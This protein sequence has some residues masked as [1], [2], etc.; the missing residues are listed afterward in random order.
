MNLRFLE[1]FLWIAK[2]GSFS[3]AAAKLHTTQT[4]I[5][6]R[7]RTLEQ[8][9]GVRLFERDSRKVVL[10]GAGQQLLPYAEQLL[11]LAQTM[12]KIMVDRAA[13][14]GIVT[15]GVIESVVHSWLPE[16]LQAV[17][18][19]FPNVVLEVRSDSTPRLRDELLKGAIDIVILTEQ[20]A[21][22]AFEN[23]LLM[24]YPMYWCAH[25]DV[26]VKVQTANDFEKL[27][28][29]QPVMTFMRDTDA[30]RDVRRALANSPNVRIN[31]FSSIAAIISVATSG[32]GVAGLA[33]PV[34]DKY[35]SSHQLQTIPVGPTL[36]DLPLYMAYPVTPNTPVIE[37]IADLIY[38]LSRQNIYASQP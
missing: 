4:A 37:Q 10:T 28:D 27:L 29:T 11:G 35:V 14:Q 26:A 7:I 16:L 9:F 34:I 22:P 25:P 21:D 19:Q 33:L 17:N 32:Y 15:L 3:A 1:A 5:S 36:N 18:Q 12:R 30:Y 24:A 13:Q 31:P 8:D 6:D 38:A 23:L 2:L 20:V